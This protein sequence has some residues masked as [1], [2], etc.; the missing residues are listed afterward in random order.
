MVGDGST[1]QSA[2][3]ESRH[4]GR[5]NELETQRHRPESAWP[6]QAIVSF[7]S[8]SIDFA[9]AVLERVLPSVC[10][11]LSGNDLVQA[12]LGTGLDRDQPGNLLGQDLDTL[13]SADLRFGE[14]VHPRQSGHC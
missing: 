7:E 11:G 5:L 10:P 12:L 6:P 2:V 13:L 1:L 9:E 14:L 8:A 3:E 4:A